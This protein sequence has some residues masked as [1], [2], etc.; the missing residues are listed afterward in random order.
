MRGF[1]VGYFRKRGAERGYV[2]DKRRHSGQIDPEIQQSVE[3]E[4]DDP[5]DEHNPRVV[6]RLL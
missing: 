2:L 5:N 6:K 3:G 4:G 1:A